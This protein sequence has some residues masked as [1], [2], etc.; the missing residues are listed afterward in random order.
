MISMILRMYYFRVLFLK[1]HL[2]TF[3]INK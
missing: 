1:A 3:G 2:N